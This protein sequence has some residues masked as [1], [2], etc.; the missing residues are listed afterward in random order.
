MGLWGGKFSRSPF[1]NFGAKFGMS[2]AAYFAE[3]TANYYFKTKMQSVKYG[4]YRKRKGASYGIKS[5][6][7]SWLYSF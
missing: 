1:G 4:D 5:W 3:Y 7:Y 6:A 2:S